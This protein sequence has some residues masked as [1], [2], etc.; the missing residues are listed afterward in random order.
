M[1]RFV[2]PL[3]VVALLTAVALAPT[4]SDYQRQLG[5]AYGLAAQKIQARSAVLA[6][7][8]AAHPERF[9][10]GVPRP[11]KAPSAVWINPPKTFSEEQ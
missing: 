6:A 1:K 5:D 9:P 4:S 10:H 11:Q 8:H 2:V 3:A 7:A